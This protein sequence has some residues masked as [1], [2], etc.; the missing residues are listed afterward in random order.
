M[1]LQVRCQIRS[2]FLPTVV[3][4]LSFAI[5]LHAQNWIQWPASAGGNDHYYALT[6]TET[7]WEAAEKLA[8]SWGGTLA[9]IT[10]S[11]E[12]NFIN[13]TFL[14][15]L[16]ERRPVWIGLMANPKHG[17]FRWQLGP[18]KMEIGGTPQLDYH[19]V[20]GEPL[21]Y[22]NWHPNQP[23]NFPPGENYV[24]INWF[25]SDNRGAKGDWND[26]PENGTTGFGGATTGPYFGIVER[27]YDPRLPVRRQPDNF[28]KMFHLT[29]LIPL[30]II[31]LIVFR[32]TINGR[33][34]NDK[35]I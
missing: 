9:T 30:L 15:G 14:K 29:L 13:R 31:L 20:T 21:R 18:V 6:A 16:L 27:D 11:N 3:A 7:N 8:V 34:M 23:D 4:F 28:K 24:A 25:Y 22:A 5:T 35:G 19:W 32:R 12:Q 1:I 33:G 10:S 2:W 17:P 26:T